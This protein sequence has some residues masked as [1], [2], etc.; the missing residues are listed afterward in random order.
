ME[1]FFYFGDITSSD[2]ALS[3]PVESW[4][5][6]HPEDDTT[7]HLYFTPFNEM[8]FAPQKD[9]DIM[10]L[11]IV[12]NKHREV[13]TAIAESIGDEENFIVIADNDNSIYIDSNIVTWAGV[14]MSSDV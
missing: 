7:L 6:S 11:T 10:V 1:K 8:G 2:S 5:G 13:L 14:I 3:Y 9:N 12:T 4:R